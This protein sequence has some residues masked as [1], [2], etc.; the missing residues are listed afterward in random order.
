MEDLGTAIDGVFQWRTRDVSDG[1]YFV[2]VQS[3]VG[4]ST[5]KVVVVD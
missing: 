1:I 2:R 4:V 5:R 3:D